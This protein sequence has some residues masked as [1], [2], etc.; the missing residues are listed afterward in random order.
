MSATFTLS[1]LAQF[2]G[3]DPAKPIYLA[4]KGTVYDVTEKRDAYQPG[5]SYHI[6]AGKDASRALAVRSL[7]AEDCTSDLTGVTDAQLEALNNWVKFY[8]D[9]YPKVGTVSA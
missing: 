2:N 7:K 3:V 6:L 9:K 5:G 1:E 8:N 4:L